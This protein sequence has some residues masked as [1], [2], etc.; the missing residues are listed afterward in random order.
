MPEEE[1]NTN[2]NNTAAA[3]ALAG[4][5]AQGGAPPAAPAAAADQQADDDQDGV[6]GRLRDARSGAPL[7]PRARRAKKAVPVLRSLR[8]RY[9]QAAAPLLRTLRDTARA[10]VALKADS[11]AAAGRYVGQ[12]YLDRRF[13][14]ALDFG[15]GARTEQ[16]QDED[17]PAFEELAA[18][19]QALLAVEV[20]DAGAQPPLPHEN[21]A[22]LWATVDAIETSEHLTTAAGGA[23]AAAAPAVAP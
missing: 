6:L 16:R 8:W 21:D 13:L 15:P 14:F 1:A 3:A 17:P 19:A 23:A 2:N 22:A 18:D 5:Q 9:A 11:H 7:T 12:A 4:I 10:L 20:A